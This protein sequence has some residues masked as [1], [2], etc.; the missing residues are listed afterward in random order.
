MHYMGGGYGTDPNGWFCGCT[1]D[2]NNPC[3]S[4]LECYSNICQNGRCATTGG[5]DGAMCM[6]N[7][8]DISVVCAEGC[9]CIPFENF[10]YC[11][12]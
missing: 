1:F 9:Q 6:N 3:T 10:G 5:R 4:P 8:G 7:E 11:K 12:C 2:G